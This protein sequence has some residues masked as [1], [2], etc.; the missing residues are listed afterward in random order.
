[1]GPIVTTD[2]DDYIDSGSISGLTEIYE[3]QI[4]DPTG[5]GTSSATSTSYSNT[6]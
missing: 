2:S 5:G 4:E 3:E 1:M 6:T